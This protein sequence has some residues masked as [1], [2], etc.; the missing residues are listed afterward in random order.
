MS[1][2][3]IKEDREKNGKRSAPATERL[4]LAH[5]ERKYFTKI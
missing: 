4:S 1:A 5:L 2:D 3:S